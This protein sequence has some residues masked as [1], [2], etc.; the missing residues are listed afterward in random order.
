MPRTPEEEARDT[1]DRRLAACDWIVQ[2]RE[3]ADISAPPGVAIREFPLVGGDAADYL[4][5]ANGKAI[6]VAGTKPAG[7]ALPTFTTELVCEVNF[8]NRRRLIP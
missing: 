1:I 8:D 2:N 4:L 5:C 6:G 3:E 7:T